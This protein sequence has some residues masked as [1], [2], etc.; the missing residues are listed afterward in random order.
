MNKSRIEA[1][2]DGVF[3]IV[4]TLLILDVRFPADRPLTLETLADQCE[5]RRCQDGC[6]TS[7]SAGSALRHVEAPRWSF[8]AEKVAQPLLECQAARDAR[9][10]G[11]YEFLN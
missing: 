9:D 11:G 10:G 2:S 7:C 8:V 5:V 6:T 1:L 3:A 4:I